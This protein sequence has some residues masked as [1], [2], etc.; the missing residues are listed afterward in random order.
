MDTA[1][2]YGNQEA[3]GDAIR[4]SGAPREKLF[5]TTKVWRED[6]RHDDVLRVYDKVLAQ[7]RLDYVDLLLVHWPNNEIPMEET[8][9]AMGRLID[10]GRIRACGVSNLVV[11]Q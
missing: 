3:V 2:N 8:F 7:L 6:L 5:V 10:D 4:A 11:V 9:A 1:D